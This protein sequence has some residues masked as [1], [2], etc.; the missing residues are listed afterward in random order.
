MYKNTA[1]K[2]DKLSRDLTIFSYNK[3][4]SMIYDYLIMHV[5]LKI[6][7]AAVQSIKTFVYFKYSQYI[8]LREIITQSQFSDLFVPTPRKFLPLPRSL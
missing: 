7:R 8:Y 5:P 1:G 4:L 6:V 3:R 2:L